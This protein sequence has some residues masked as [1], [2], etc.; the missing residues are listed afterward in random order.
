MIPYI[1]DRLNAW[2][3]WRLAQDEA[4]V[5]RPR[6]GTYDLAGRADS[7]ETIRPRMSITQVVAIECERTDRCVKALEP[8]LEQTVRECYLRTTSYLLVAADL[9]CSEKTLYRRL[10]RA[11]NLILGLLQDIEA[12]V[13]VL[14]WCATSHESAPRA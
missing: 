7:T 3:Y 1:N 4:G 5:T 10:D 11:H 13:E 6:S 2:A 8:V 14:P 9:G 12:G